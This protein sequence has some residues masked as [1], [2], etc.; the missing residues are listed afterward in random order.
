MV[1]FIGVFLCFK[2]FQGRS[3]IIGKLVRTVVLFRPLFKGCGS[4]DAAAFAA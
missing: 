1:S 3:G 4:E 2:L